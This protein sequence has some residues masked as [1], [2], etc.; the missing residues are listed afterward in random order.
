MTARDDNPNWIPDHGLA[1]SGMTNVIIQLPPCYLLPA[2]PAH[3][4]PVACPEP[5]R[6]EGST[7]EGL[8]VTDFIVPP[9]TYQN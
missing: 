7:V 1:V 9:T 4:E 8:L 5:G 3:P 2:C 6:R